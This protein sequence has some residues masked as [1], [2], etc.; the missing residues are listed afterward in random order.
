[1]NIKKNSKVIKLSETQLNNIV[2]RVIYE[3]NIDSDSDDIP[4]RLDLDDDNDGEIDSIDNNFGEALKHITRFVDDIRSTQKRYGM[5][6][7]D[8]SYEIQNGIK[9]LAGQI[10]KLNLSEQFKRKFLEKLED[11]LNGQLK[12]V[13]GGRQ[14]YNMVKEIAQ[15]IN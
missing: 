11:K 4:D 8:I 5:R 6:G 12:R 10:S 15:R 3:N 7:R 9:K 13:M 14:I 1:M 2:K